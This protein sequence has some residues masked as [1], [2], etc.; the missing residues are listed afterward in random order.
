MQ[1]VFLFYVLLILP[2]LSPLAQ[3]IPSK[4]VCSMVVINIFLFLAVSVFSLF[5]TPKAEKVIYIILLVITII[6]SA[7]F[8]GYLLFARVLLEQNSI[9]SLFETNTAE[10]KEFIMHY[11]NIGIIMGILIYIIIPI[12]M[13][14]KMKAYKPLKIHK[15]KITFAASLSIIICITFVSKLSQSIY[16]INFYN[17]F[18]AYK[19]Q[20]YKEDEGI[21]NRQKLQYEVNVKEDI[22]KEQ[23]IV[24]VIGESLTRNHMQIY[25]YGRETT[26]L[27]AAKRDS[28]S[29]YKDVVSPQVH[30]IPV[31]RSV[32]S[33]SNR[34]HPEY[35]VQKPS[36]FELFN[37][38]GYETYFISN[39]PFGGKNKTSYDVLL[40]LAKHKY[41]MTTPK[42]RF[43]DV[44]VKKFEQILTDTINKR[45]FI[46][47]HLMGN[48]MAYQFRYPS[49]FNVFD[50]TK[51]SYIQDESFRN[52][53]AKK[54]IDEY[55]NSVLYNDHVI[56]QTISLLQKRNL[57]NSAMIYFSDHGEE[58]Y[59]FR[60]FAG[61]AYEKLS[62]YMCQIP[63]ILWLS[64]DYLNGRKDISIDT[65]R[66]FSIENVIYSITDLAGLKYEDY[67]SSKSLFSKEF[68]PEIR[69]VGDIRYD[70]L[71]YGKK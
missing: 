65:A 42:R 39:Q 58:L 6:P 66:P 68:I 8:L 69:Y 29:I 1:L 37:R 33:F 50:H 27:L 46:V 47:I 3:N 54:L 62:V 11:F 61:H 32:L 28:V 26:P 23:T 48:H 14:W 16:F 31:L 19:I 57:P 49:K 70:D 20:T 40:E 64:P 56:S 2:L 25:G 55:D 5:F 9:T 71:Q 15:H 36:A 51:D 18:I 38:A 30:T 35:F 24:M 59:D 67:D 60:N 7:I 4:E 44:T 45:K 10:S 34:K 22:P 52:D 21:K 53:D 12:I 63:F 43:D 13:I 17:T 41:D